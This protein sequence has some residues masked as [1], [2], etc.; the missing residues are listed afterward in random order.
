MAGTADT[1]APA[2]ASAPSAPR[3]PGCVWHNG[4]FLAPDD[5]RVSP[6]DFGWLYGDGLF[7]TLRTYGRR[8]FLLSAH[9]ARL[10]RSADQLGFPPLPSEAEFEAAVLGAV[11]RAGLPEAYIRI[12]VTRGIGT[13]GLDPAGCKTPT[14]LVAALTLRTWSAA[15]YSEGARL[16]VLWPRGHQDW[17]LPTI[18]SISY[19]RTVIARAELKRRGADEGIYLDED[20][21]VTETSVSNLF[22][23]RGKTVLT[24]PATRCLPGITRAEV[25]DIA[26][27]AGLDAR[28]E[29][30]RPEDLRAADEVFL[31]GSLAELVPAVQL[32][33]HMLGSGRPGPVWNQLRSLYLARTRM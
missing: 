18:K 1:Q 24:P 6:F 29:S 11:E 8:P 10:A 3:T 26:R 22:I 17:P 19:Q 4:V 23:V 32:D 7:E 14:V 27:E 13:A 9:L 15:L 5:V 33:G 25:L 30:L 20:G 2:V 21:C 31:T 16:T 28:E 12:T